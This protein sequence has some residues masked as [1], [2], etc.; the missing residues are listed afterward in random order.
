MNKCPDCG[1]PM[2]RAGM[3]VTNRRG[4][5]KQLWKCPKC[6]RRTVNPV[7]EDDHAATTLPK[8]SGETVSR[9]S[10]V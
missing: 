3:S 10:T 8:V 4:D 9:I 7:M 5:Q 1:A 2:V 6:R